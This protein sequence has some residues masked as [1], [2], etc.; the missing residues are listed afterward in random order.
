M[1]RQLR[2]I[3]SR[4]VLAAALLGL[5]LVLAPD[6]AA[7]PGDT[8]VSVGSPADLF[9]RNAQNE[10]AL[11]IDPANPQVI[12][13][14]ANDRIDSSPC[15]G[16]SCAIPPGVGRAGVYFSF[17]GA[18]SWVQP[19]YTG[20]SA[21]DGTA[22]PGPI[23]TLPGFYER[24]LVSVADPALAFGPRPGSDGR[25]SWSDGSRLYYAV[26]ATNFDPSKRAEA[27][28]GLTAIT[29][30][31]TDDVHAAAAGVNEA[32]LP[33]VIVSERLNQQTFSDKEALWV[34]N[35]ASSPHFGTVYV[36]WT[37]FRAG[38]QAMM[39]A[40]SVDGGTDWSAPKQLA[41][42]ALVP[43]KHARSGCAMRTDSTGTLYVFWESVTS[44]EQAAQLMARSH[45]GGRSFQR[46]RQ[47]A[48]IGRTGK[49]DALGFF[50]CDGVRGTF[51]NE[52]P[53]VGV[54]NGAPSGAGAP[55]TLVLAWGDGRLGLDH[56]QALVQIS[57]DGGE[58]WLGPVDAAESGDRPLH[59]AVA[60]S[61]NGRDVFVTY[62]A[63]LDPWRETTSE[64]R[65]V[66]GV[67]R[68]ASGDL[69]RWTTVYRGPVGDA[70]ASDRTNLEFEF[71]GD[72]NTVVATNDFAV[73][74]WTD[75]RDAALCPAVL[76]YRQ[77]LLTGSPLPRPSPGMDCPPSFGNT[78]I[79]ATR[80]G[81]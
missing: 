34:D 31:R 33:P 42:A 25:F 30:S 68:R 15:S 74:A 52:F 67:V 51:C 22:G 5:P 70:R 12:A 73:G 55:D 23:G 28:P 76:A 80:L 10:P 16:S 26:V 35:A 14:G 71:L 59:P 46:P 48:V 6:V 57:T 36:C 21:R 49:A 40:R 9:P 79:Y 17:D 72:Y 58:T 81:P 1:G 11:A 7:D 75:V 2:V 19:T 27:F 44:H 47:V 64:V 3:D 37:S 53:S 29:V 62:Q 32:W 20:W 39:I 43:G 45:D 13:G 63:L 4:L 56:E 41:E 38:A 60:V 69:T 78:D 8:L 61:P 18:S 66:Q 24:G 54:A 65:R 77:S 50:F